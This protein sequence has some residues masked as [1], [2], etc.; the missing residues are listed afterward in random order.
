VRESRRVHGDHRLTRED[1]L[2]GRRFA[3]EIALCGAPIEDH[4]A[5]SDTA[6]RYV[7]E[8]IGSSVYGIPY[9][10]LLPLGVEGLL[11]AG[12]CFSATHDAHASAR[13][14][15]TCMAMGQAAGTAAALAAAGDGVPRAVS[16][17]T[18][19]ERLALDGALLEPVELT[20]GEEPTR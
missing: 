11:V 8:G 1:V 4:G 15:A 17:D 14:M 19:R 16:G 20:A 18:L 2:G 10:T 9:R 13:S 5:G 7:G 12:R 3:D 6:W